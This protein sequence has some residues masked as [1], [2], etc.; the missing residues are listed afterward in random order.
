VRQTAEHRSNLI[1]QNIRFLVGS[2]ESSV[3]RIGVPYPTVEYGLSSIFHVRDDTS[4]LVPKSVNER[5][6]VLLEVVEFVRI[7]DISQKIHRFDR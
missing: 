3:L 6:E 7:V 1:V 4:I 2:I 5:L